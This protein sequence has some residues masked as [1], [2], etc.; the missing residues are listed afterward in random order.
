MF[1]GLL[2]AV[3]L[4][5]DVPAAPTARV[6]DYAGLLAPDDRQRLES[7]IAERER[8]TSAQMAIAIFR[9]LDGASLEDFSIRLAE[10]WRIGQKGLDNGVILVVFVDDRRVRMEVGYGLEAVIPDIVAGRIVSEAIAPRFREQRYAA[11][12]QA[13]V[14]EVYSRVET[15]PQPGD[16]GRRVV[17]T[18]LAGFLLLIVVIA[19]LLGFE[20]SRSRR[21]VGRRGYTAGRGGWAGPIIFPGGRHGGGW[22]GGG[23]GRFGGGG[24]SGSW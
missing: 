13:A 8:A 9:A 19:L 5:L 15:G 10:R 2:L 16:R 14:R 3:A 4:A 23:G 7:L 20:A 22:G 21:F 24:A 6:N 12:L 11:G 18:P 17:S 1:L